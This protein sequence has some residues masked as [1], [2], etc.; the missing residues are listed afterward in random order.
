[1]QILILNKN[2]PI[3]DRISRCFIFKSEISKIA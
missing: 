2:Y 3:R 1:R